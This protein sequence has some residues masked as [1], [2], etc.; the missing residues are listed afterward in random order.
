MMPI[1]LD[2]GCDGVDSEDVRYLQTSDFRH[3]TPREMSPPNT[4]SMPQLFS[5]F[6]LVHN[7]STHLRTVLSYLI[8]QKATQTNEYRAVNYELCSASERHTITNIRNTSHNTHQDNCRIWIFRGS[9]KRFSGSDL[10]DTGLPKLLV[11]FYPLSLYRFVTISRLHH[12]ILANVF[13]ILN[14]WS[15]PEGLGYM[16]KFIRRHKQTKSEWNASE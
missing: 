8:V 16:W 15:I 5:H 7:E 14:I 13:G 3:T 12:F 11:T 10:L 9:W 1:P 4:K 6:L 2:T